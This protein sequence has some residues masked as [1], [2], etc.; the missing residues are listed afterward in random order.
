MTQNSMDYNQLAAELSRLRDLIGDDNIMA[1]SQGTARIVAVNQVPGMPN[2]IC[3]ACGLGNYC[4]DISCPNAASE[5]KRLKAVV[6]DT[7]SKLDITQCE[8]DLL[9]SQNQQLSEKLQFATSEGKK[10]ADKL[11]EQEFFVK[12]AQH[13]R[14]INEMQIDRLQQD[15]ARL[16]SDSKTSSM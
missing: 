4:G 6:L 13:T 12:A 1:L 5:I 10:L 2:A 7:Q 16:S 3:H 9:K 11:A 8:L 14:E 15:I